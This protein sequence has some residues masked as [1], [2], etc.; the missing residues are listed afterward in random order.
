MSNAV[1]LIC[2]LAGIGMALYGMVIRYTEMT[3]LG[4]FVAWLN[5]TAAWRHS[6]E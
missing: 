3:M 1:A 4:L 6:N 2:A 5:I